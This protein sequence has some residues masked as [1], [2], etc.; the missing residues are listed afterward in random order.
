ME[1][2]DHMRRHGLFGPSDVDASNA[3]DAGNFE[4]DDWELDVP[5]CPLAGNAG[6]KRDD[7][8]GVSDREDWKYGNGPPI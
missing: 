8:F 3:I 2:T 5:D 6:D 7:V 4:C 1:G